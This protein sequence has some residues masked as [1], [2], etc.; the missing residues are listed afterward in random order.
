[1]SKPADARLMEII[2]AQLPEDLLAVYAE[3]GWDARNSL[4]F[5]VVMVIETA[6]RETDKRSRAAWLDEQKRLRVAAGAIQNLPPRYQAIYG[7]IAGHL[8]AEGEAMNDEIRMLHPG[9]GRPAEKGKWRLAEHIARV[10]PLLW[11]VAPRE[12]CPG[13]QGAPALAHINIAKALWEALTNEHTSLKSWQMLVK[14]YHGKHQE[15]FI[16]TPE[17]AKR[18]KPLKPKN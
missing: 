12:F 3:A 11:D 4:H 9:S 15:L 17:N 8:M 6:K 14:K 2:L 1:M 5:V 18:I 13:P 7:G 10:V 16:G